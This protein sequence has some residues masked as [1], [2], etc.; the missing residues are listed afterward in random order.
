MHIK[1]K[2]RNLHQPDP[3]GYDIEV[4]ISNED[5]CYSMIIEKKKLN[6]QTIKYAWLLHFVSSLHRYIHWDKVVV[7]S[8]TTWFQTRG[9]RKFYESSGGTSAFKD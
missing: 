9:T 1:S 8:I 3:S 5:P 7:L 6:Q 4:A 2:A